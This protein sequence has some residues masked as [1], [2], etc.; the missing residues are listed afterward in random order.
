MDITTI[1]LSFS[2]SLALSFFFK[3]GFQFL[4]DYCY[5]RMMGKAADKVIEKHGD[6]IIRGVVHAVVS[7]IRLVE[8]S[9]ERWE[10]VVNGEESRTNP[11]SEAGAQN[12]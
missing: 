4:S 2:A 5:A 1:V 11:I 10:D 3:Y 9:R 12:R 7:R 8:V 6:D